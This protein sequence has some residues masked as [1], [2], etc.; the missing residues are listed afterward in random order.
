MSKTVDVLVPDIGNFHDVPIVEVLVAPGAS[1]KRDDPIAV[2]ES[3]KASMDVPSPYAGSVVEVLVKVGDKVSVGARLA[4]MAVDDEITLTPTGDA[5]PAAVPGKPAPA[6]PWQP[7]T[8]V[9]REDRSEA[10]P[11]RRTDTCPWRRG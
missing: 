2:L 9:P 1:L 7:E 4:T 5:G 10:A 6:G 8:P 11:G 3:D